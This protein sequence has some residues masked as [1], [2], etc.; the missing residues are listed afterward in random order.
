M[1]ST[2]LRNNNKPLRRQILDLIPEH[3]FREAV[4]R[5]QTDKHCSKYKTYD[6]LLAMIFG[7]LKEE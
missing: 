7:Q 4:C 2:K 6:E 5:Y 3:I 1:G